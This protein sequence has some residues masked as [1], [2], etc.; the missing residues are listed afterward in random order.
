MIF[1]PQPAVVYII[2]KLEL[3][4]AQKVCLSL[5]KE[6]HKRNSVVYLI[7]GDEGILV[8]QVKE[9]SNVFLLKSLKRE[10]RLLSLFSEVKTFFSL[11]RILRSLKRKYPDLVVHTHGSKAGALGRLAAFCAGIGKRV[12]TIHGFP[13][14][15]HTNFLAWL[16]LYS[17][18]LL[19]APLTTHYICV[20]N[21]DVQTGIKKI[22]FFKEKYSVI[23]AAVDTEHFYTPARQTNS[24]PEHGQ[25]FTFGTVACFK[26]QKNIFDTLRA[27][28]Y[29]YE[30]NRATRLEIVGDG[31]L[32]PAIEAWIKEHNLNTVITLHGWQ[33]D[34]KP[35]LSNWHSFVLTSLWEGLPCAL[36]EARLCKLPILCYDTG[37]IRDVI[38]HGVNGFVYP[39]HE[40]KQLA[41]G[42]LSLTTDELLF[43]ALRHY[44]D[45][46]TDFGITTMIH[47]HEQLYS[48]L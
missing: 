6:L 24:F 8:D 19:C 43:V 7:T 34:V 16:I 45:N 12:H 9:M 25:P 27:F 10:V 38:Y 13:F 48:I 31:I 26:K 4:G 5:F 41:R 2:T 1:S 47:K 39:Q 40:W 42:M 36:I 44:P 33:P 46:L 23:R 28:H 37:G 15:G 17:I 35:F 11:V 21:A 20:S 22:P 14:H 18:E 29:V 3:G 32:R 30:Q